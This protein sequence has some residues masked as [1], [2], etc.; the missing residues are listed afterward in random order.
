MK[1]TLNLY[2]IITIALLIFITANAM[3]QEKIS[4][5][6]EID[7]TTHNFGDI[8]LE[9]GP[10][11]CTYTITNVGDKAEVI[12][13]VTTSCGC[14]KAIWTREPILPGKTGKISVT[15]SNDEGAYPFDKNVTV[16]ISGNNKPVIL[17]LRGIAHARKKSIDELFPVTYGPLGMKTSYHKCGNIEQGGQRSESASIANLSN[18]AVKVEFSGIS[19]NLSVSI[20]PNPIPAR[21]AAEMTFT[22]KADRNLWGKN[23]Y[24]ATPVLNGKTYR[25]GDGKKDIGFWAFT[26]DNF[27]HLTDQERMKGPR[28]GFD[29]STYSFGKIKKGKVVTAEF[30]FKNEG[31]GTLQ[32]HKADFSVDGCTITEIPDTAP[33]A[34]TSFKVTVD[35]SKMPLGEALAMITLIT[36]SPLRP[37]VVLFVSGWLE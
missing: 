17:K 2:R 22:V 21:S 24:F 1:S 18:S 19:E 16:Y 5:T 11:D 28:P 30:T 34:K 32:V 9:D 12:Y 20:K 23:E 6:L 15:Y 37:T 31:A 27:N 13:N 33:G 35:T 26:K 29:Q 8:L 14:T 7:K 10:V 25:N 36:N 4:S 3:S